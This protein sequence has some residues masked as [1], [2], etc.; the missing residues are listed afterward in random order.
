MYHA[1]VELRG[2][3]NFNDHYG[4]AFGGALRIGSITRVTFVNN[5]ASQ[6]G[7]A[8]AVQNYRDAIDTTLILNNHC[9]IQYSIGC[10]N[11]N[12]P[13]KWTVSSLLKICWHNH[14]LCSQYSIQQSNCKLQT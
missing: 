8:M 1:R 11:K 6:F 7:G 13:F 14:T 5:S 10:D 3:L 9:F 4:A 12:N 2:E